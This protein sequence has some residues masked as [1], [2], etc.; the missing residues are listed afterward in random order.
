MIDRSLAES[1]LVFSFSLESSNSETSRSFLGDEPLLFFD[2]K[3]SFNDELPNV[4]D[5]PTLLDVA[6]AFFDAELTFVGDEPQL[7]EDKP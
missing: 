5:E 1:E 4:G 2:I 7:L 6:P 3:C